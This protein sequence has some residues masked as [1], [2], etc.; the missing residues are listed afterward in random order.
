MVSPKMQELDFKNE[1]SELALEYVDEIVTTDTHKKRVSTHKIAS[2]D[3]NKQDNSNVVNQIVND[4]KIVYEEAMS[5][6]Y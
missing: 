6:G 1:L 4:I 5:E 3:I 2:F